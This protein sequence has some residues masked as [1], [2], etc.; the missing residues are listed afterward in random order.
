M[1]KNKGSQFIKGIFIQLTPLLFWTAV[2]ILPKITDSVVN[3]PKDLLLN[4]LSIYLI[5]QTILLLWGFFNI[6]KHW[7][8]FS[9][10]IILIIF[11]LLINIIS[12]VLAYFSYLI[13]TDSWNFIG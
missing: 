9:Y 3:L 12:Y 4:I 5:L 11:S 10:S 7:N 1:E 2:F 13:L 6:K 8:F